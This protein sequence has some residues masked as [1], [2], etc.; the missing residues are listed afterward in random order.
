MA[1]YIT[2]ILDEVN[3]DTSKLKEYKDN[4]AIRLVFEY[5]FLE[6]NKFIL[7]EGNPPYKEDSAPIGMSPANLYQ[8]VRRFYIFKRDDLTPTKRESLFISLLESVHPSEAKLLL[9]IKDQDL[10]K[11]YSKIT[12]DLVE[13]EGF[14]P[15]REKAVEPKKAVKKSAPKKTSTRKQK[16][17]SKESQTDSDTS[18]KEDERVTEES[19]IPNEEAQN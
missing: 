7:P 18:N 14:I 19:G 16:T 15:R 9:A 5:A 4:A 17:S 10:P 6:E 13:S 11:L 8:E 1:K 12:R 2:E 3:K